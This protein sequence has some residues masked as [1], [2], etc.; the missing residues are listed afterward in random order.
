MYNDLRAIKGIVVDAGH[1]GEDPGAVNGNIYEKDFTLEVSEYIYNRLRELGLPVYITRDTDETLDRDE[2]V[3]RILSAFG[4]DPNVIVL[5]NHINAGGGEGAEVVYAL[6]NS[7]ELAKTVLDSIGQE[8]Q[9]TRKYYQRR[10]PSDPS[11]DYYFIHRLTGRTQ[12]LLIEYGFIDNTNDLRKLQSNLLTYGEA[13]VRA[14]AEYTNTPYT[15]PEGVESNVYV[16]QRGDTLY[17]IANKLNVTVAELK[18]ANNLT[19]NLLNIG[20]RLIIPTTTPPNQSEDYVTYEVQRGDSLYSIAR[21][22]N[23]TVNDL[24]NFN[25]LSSTNLSIGQKLLIPVTNAVPEGTTKYYE[26]QRGDSLYSIANKFDVTVDD[27]I[28]ANNLSSTILQIGDRLIIPNYSNVEDIVPPSNDSSDLLVYTVQ[29]GDSLY[30]IA[31]KFNITV[32]EIKNANNLTSNLLTIG[33]QLFIP[34]ET[35]YIVYYVQ[36]GDNL[37]DI[38]RRYNTTVSEIKNINN[39]TGN[40]LTIGQVLQIPA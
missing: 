29:S 2:R 18:A 1:G 20:Q 21:Q 33:Q 40:L 25:Q 30:S 34:A 36:S 27:I 8:G 11:K 13:V 37:Y 16:V 3:N 32:S 19:S 7:D 5:S 35:G 28:R 26:V 10:L 38:A 12:P 17:S 9:A 15:S 6:R 14:I 4:N 24:I 39:L 31:K 23:T 22:F